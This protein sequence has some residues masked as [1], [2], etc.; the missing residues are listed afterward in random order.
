MAFGASIVGTP[1]PPEILYL[2]EVS[3]NGEFI[4]VQAELRDDGKG[5]DAKARD[6]FYSGTPL[7][8]GSEEETER[9]FRI[10]AEYFGKTVVSETAVFPIT[11]LPLGYRPSDPDTL[12]DSADG[13]D[14]VFTNEVIVGTLA[15]ISPRRVR[16]IVAEV[17]ETLGLQSDAIGIAGYIPAIN[18]YLVEF[19]GNGTLEGVNRV[20]SEFQ[21]HAEVTYASYNFQG[22]PA[23]Q[24]FLEDIGIPKLRLGAGT[25]P[26]SGPPLY[27]S[28]S[29]GVAVMEAGGVDC[30]DPDLIG[31]CANVTDLLSS[32]G[33]F[34]TTGS[35]THATKVA[36]L[37]AGQ[38]DN[39]FTVEGV[40]G[41][42]AWDTKLFPFL[43][44]SIW[45]LNLSI[46]CAVNAGAEVGS[47]IIHILNISRESNSSTALETSVCEAVCNNMLVVAAA[48]NYA[49]PPTV[50]T[51]DAI[52]RYPAAY[53]VGTTCTCSPTTSLLAG[54]R[55][56]R[57]GA[58]DMAKQRGDSCTKFGTKS[59][60]GDIYAPGWGIPVD[61]ASAHSSDYATSWAAPLV[62]GCA[63]IRGSVQ[64]WKGIS[65]NAGAVETRLRETA[66]GTPALMNCLA[67]V[68]D[69]YDIVFVLDRSG[70]M[71]STANIDTSVATNRWD[72]LSNA[73]EGLIPLITNSAPPDSRFGLT[74]F[75]GTV[76]P[77]SPSGLAPI[78]TNLSTTVSA[79]LGVTPGGSTAMGLGLKDGIAKMTDTMRP[80]VVVLFTDGEQNIPPEVRIGGCT[81]TDGSLVNPDCPGLPGSVKIIAI[82][83][84]QPSADYLATLQALSSNNRGSLIV[85]DNGTAFTDECTGDLS[86][87]FDCAIAPALMGNSPQMVISY[88]G[89]LSDTVTL[90]AFDLNKNVDRLLIKISFSRR[91]ELPELSAILTGVRIL[92]DGID[93][94]R[95][96]DPVF[97]SEHTN[98][99]LLKTRFSYQGE[100]ETSTIAP[101]GGYTMQM[102][103]PSSLRP[104]L[105]YRVVPYADDHR[106]RMEWQVTP[107]APRVNQPFYPAIRLSWRGQPLTNARVEALIQVPGTDLGNLLANHPR[108]VGMRSTPDAG[109]PGY[110]KYLY[111]L[112]N[113]PGFLAEL[114]PHEKKLTLTHQGGGLYTA[115]YTPGD[116]SGIYQIIYQVNA[117]DAD[118]AKIQRKAVQ[119]LYV[120][121]GDIDLDRSKV[122]SSVKDNK[123]LI[124]LR[125]I[126]TYGRLIGPA[127]ESAFSV[128]GTG[129][130]LES[131]TDH[132]DGRY[133][134]VLTGDPDAEVAVKLL[135]EE[136]YHGPAS[137]L[138]KD[139]LGRLLDWQN[140]VCLHI[141]VIWLIIAVILL[142]FVWLVWLVWLVWRRAKHVSTP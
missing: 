24:W 2:D 85:T 98:S 32:C 43:V 142:L 21:D 37:V 102:A 123:I 86:A 7:E 120:R 119:S 80:R 55:I 136:F 140:V 16:M 108:R 38:G 99:I 73:V 117:E 67:A 33:A 45:A 71:S 52:D 106:L 29:I 20:I 72:A 134:L 141:W 42:V 3:S 31:K 74:L 96:F 109:S 23:A 39:A 53:D 114:R 63:A 56:L 15:G 60:P 44:D 125:P 95:Y 40:D 76:L 41:G 107:S 129:I 5:R 34:T 68:E 103:A 101:E 116:V 25:P 105:G 70:S 75:A 88:R 94:T 1:T 87:A 54:D 66:D 13:R 90:P 18:A 47:Q 139:F 48:G 35:G 121:F 8:L 130:R 126:T 30:S 138:G 131:V 65:W 46:D 64:E 89:V 128:N 11:R 6:G 61:S 58:T 28:A 100:G 118:F 97:P 9:Y 133:T 79:A 26:P 22:R 36:A 122:S 81:F 27:G 62:S 110:Q 112:E 132:Q 77:V 12:V 113:D 127:Q 4:S 124:N 135:G 78:D 83:I 91:F 14:K 50:G 92:K 111:L 84:G 57:V 19:E 51:G 115:P 93:I 49:C 82:G 137:G 59:K 17:G 104:D 10:R 69:P